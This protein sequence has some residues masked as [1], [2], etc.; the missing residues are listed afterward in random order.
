MVSLSA[1]VPHSLA[2]LTVGSAQGQYT[3]TPGFASQGCIIQPSV[4]F[5][6][7]SQPNSRF[8]ACVEDIPCSYEWYCRPSARLHSVV[9]CLSLKHLNDQL[10]S[11]SRAV[12]NFAPHLKTYTYHVCDFNT[13]ASSVCELKFSQ[14][15]RRVK[16]NGKQA[17]YVGLQYPNSMTM[18]MTTR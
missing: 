1:P 9:S 15:C 7:S 12:F 14:S 3:S 6:P 4:T 8:R 13:C 2:M 17:G 10:Y 5:P 11:R 18:T 16:G